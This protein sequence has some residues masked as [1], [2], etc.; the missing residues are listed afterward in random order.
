[1]MR[2]ITMGIG[3]NPVTFHGD[4]SGDQNKRLQRKQGHFQ[5]TSVRG[6]G[7]LKVEKVGRLIF[8]DF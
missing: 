6:G 4:K 1:M 2:E 5:D 3:D 7:G 8:D